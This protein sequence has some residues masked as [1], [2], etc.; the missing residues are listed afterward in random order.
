MN[1]Q[2]LSYHKGTLISN[3][4]VWEVQS[5]NSWIIFYV[6]QENG[7]QAIVQGT[8]M[9]SRTIII[10]NCFEILVSEFLELNTAFNGGCKIIEL[11]LLKFN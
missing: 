6:L 1:S 4:T 11:S 3:V 8:P 10:S 2:Q 5:G 9:D 7:K